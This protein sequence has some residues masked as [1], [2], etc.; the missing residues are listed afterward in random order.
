MRLVDKR[1]I[2]PLGDINNK[3]SMVGVDNLVSLLNLIIEERPDGIFLVQDDTP[4]STS[5]LISQ[6]G[7][8]KGLRLRLVSIPVVFRFLIKKVMPEIYK[9]LFGNLTVDD[10]KT[11]KELNFR[12]PYS[13]AE[14]IE[15]MTKNN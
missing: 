2:I 14:G 15:L 1:R 6:I 8:A 11:R 12:P 10:S 4:V 3:R 13:F 5:E 7:K 9:R